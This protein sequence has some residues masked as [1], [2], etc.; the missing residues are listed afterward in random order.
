MQHRASCA[1]TRAAPGGWRGGLGQQTESS[2]R[3]DGYW[4]VS[5]MI[6]RLKFAGQ[7]VDGGKPGA[8]GEYALA[9]GEHPPPK[10]SCRSSLDDARAPAPAGRRR[11]RRAARAA[12]R[13]QV[14]RDVVDGYVSIEAAEREYGVVIRYTGGDDRLVRLPEHY[15]IDADATARLRAT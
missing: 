5:A 6:D 13:R 7:G 15:E 14:L 1:P 8:L 10:R 4:G 2:Y 11:L 3:G 9:D 12:G